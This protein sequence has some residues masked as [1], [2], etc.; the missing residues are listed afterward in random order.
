VFAPTS[1]SS[2][3]AVAAYPSRPIS[4]IVPFPPGGPT[5]RLV[6][7]LTL[8]TGKALAATIVVINR[9]GGSTIVAAQ[10]LAL[11]KP[12]GYTIGIVP[13]SVNRHRLL[14]RTT[15]DVAK[16]FTL[17]AGVAGQTFGLVVRAS[18]PLTSVAE[19]VAFA[20]ARPETVRYGTSGIASHTHVAMEHFCALAGIRLAHIPFKGGIE[21]TAALLAGEIELLAEAAVWLPYV[22]A[23]RLR[24]IATWTERRVPRL[25]NVPTMQ[26]LGYSLVM[27]APF[28]VGGPAGLEPQVISVLA[29]ALKQA[30]LSSSFKSACDQVLAPVLYQD[31]HDFRRYVEENYA[32]EAGMVVSLGLRD[33]I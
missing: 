9:P 6:R 15:L 31:A 26:E 33:K 20:K 10:A 23:G 17:L 28:G 13:V 8:E 2:L 19:V 1:I 14:N 22:E 5:D 21:T 32:W 29:P 24:V 11:A 27:T 30:V 4:F 25:P 3:C 16:D 7:A 18:S 12:D